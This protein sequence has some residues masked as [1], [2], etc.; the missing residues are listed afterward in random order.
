MNIKRYT[1]QVDKNATKTQRHK[2]NCFPKCNFVLWCPGGSR[3]TIMG[4][5]SI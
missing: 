3:K 4:A 1:G 5:I 2:E